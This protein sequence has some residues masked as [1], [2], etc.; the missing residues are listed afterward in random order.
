MTEKL[1]RVG[2]TS[3]YIL[4]DMDKQEILSQHEKSQ[5]QA[6]IAQIESQLAEYPDP[7]QIESDVQSII[8]LINKFDGATKEQKDRVKAL[9]QDMYLAYQNEPE[10]LER[11]ELRARLDKLNKLLAQM[12]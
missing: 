8:W 1:F 7:S 11:A 10:L 9:V 5:A 6:T 2:T 4:V 3:W 12:E